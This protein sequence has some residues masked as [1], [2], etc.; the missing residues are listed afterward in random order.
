[1]AE[2]TL[3]EVLAEIVDA[4]HRYPAFHSQ[5][6]HCLFDGEELRRGLVSYECDAA[7]ARVAPV[8]GVQLTVLVTSIRPSE[9]LLQFA[10]ALSRGVMPE[11]VL[12]AAVEADRHEVSCA[13]EEHEATVVGGAFMRIPE[14]LSTE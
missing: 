2:R 8:D 13:R 4:G 1:M 6:F 9:W 12:P 3:S 14:F 10:H 11:M 5:I 7:P